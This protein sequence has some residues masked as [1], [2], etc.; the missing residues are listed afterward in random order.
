[1]QDQ[2]GKSVARTRLRDMLSAFYAEQL[3]LPPEVGRTMD[4]DL[5]VSLVGKVLDGKIEDEKKSRRS[6]TRASRAATSPPPRV[7]R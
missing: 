2:T 4:L 5:G 6:S 3:E 1:M 7:R